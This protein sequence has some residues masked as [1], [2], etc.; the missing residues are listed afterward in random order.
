MS[1]YKY[2][3]YNQ[4]GSSKTQHIQQQVDEVVGIMQENIDKVM[5]RQ[6][7]LEALNDKAD[8]LNQNALQFKRG[9]NQVRKRMWYKDMK[10]KIIIGLVILAIILTLVFSFVNFGG[11][12]A[13]QQTTP[14]AQNICYYSVNIELKSYNN[15]GGAGVSK[16]QHIQQQVDEVV[17]IMQ[18]NIDKVMERQEGL[19]ALNDKADNLNQNAMQFKRGANQVRKRM[20][21]KDMK[22]KIIIGLV[23]LAILLAIILPLVLKGNSQTQAAPQ[24]QQNPEQK[25]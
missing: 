20:W 2:W 8:N 3:S 14:P 9:A 22:F 15:A 23:I 25:S 16:T 12:S 13:P 11:N 1:I 4:G 10:F 18:E 19:E 6:E 21:Y 7:G 24:Q 17:G 5:E